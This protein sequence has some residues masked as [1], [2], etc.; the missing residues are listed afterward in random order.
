M[1][2]ADDVARPVVSPDAMPMVVLPVAFVRS[3]VMCAAVVATR[4]EV[5]AM[6]PVIVIIVSRGLVVAMVMV[7]A[8]G[9]QEAR[10]EG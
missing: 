5:T 6:E 10:Q 4:N 1:P 3:K 9:H 7:R 2:P 8:A